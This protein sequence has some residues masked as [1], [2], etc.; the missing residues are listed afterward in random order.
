VTEILRLTQKPTL[1]TAYLNKGM[2]LRTISVAGNI[3]FFF[4][5]FALTGIVLLAF[6]LSTG[7]DLPV[8]WLA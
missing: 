5:I 8:W 7:I 4:S 1:F 3:L 6:L 2:A